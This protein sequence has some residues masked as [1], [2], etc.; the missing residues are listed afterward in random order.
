LIVYIA[1]NYVTELRRLASLC[2]EKK[3]DGLKLVEEQ[4]V[5][6]TKYAEVEEKKEEAESALDKFESTNE[7]RDKPRGEL[8]EAGSNAKEQRDK[9]REELKK[10]TEKYKKMEKDGERILNQLNKAVEEA[11]AADEEKKQFC[12]FITQNKTPFFFFSF[13]KQY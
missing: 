1:L 7:E 13:G 2:E 12:K 8:K 5:W 10:V 3:Q 9:L 11:Q 4:T 6:A